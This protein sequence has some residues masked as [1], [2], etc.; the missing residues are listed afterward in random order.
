RAKVLAAIN[1]LGYRPN[2]LAQSLRRGSTRKI[3]YLIPSITNLVFAKYVEAVQAA[4]KELEFDLI[5]CNNNARRDML[6]SYLDM[7]TTS[8]I[9]G[10]IV[11]QTSTCGKIVADVCRERKVPLVVVSTPDNLDGV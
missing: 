7:L 5:L 4:L 8:R 11:T 3:I 10:V 2:Y 9:D 6:E 1:E